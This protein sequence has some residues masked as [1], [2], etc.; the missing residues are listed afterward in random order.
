MPSYSS[1]A[2]PYTPS[3]R[4]ILCHN[5]LAAYRGDAFELGVIAA[6][7]TTQLFFTHVFANLA[8]TLSIPTGN[9]SQ[10]S[11]VEMLSA[12]AFDVVEA[13]RAIAYR[14]TTANLDPIANSP[15]KHFPHSALREFVAQSDATLRHFTLQHGGGDANSPALLP[16]RMFGTLKAY[17]NMR[18]ATAVWYIESFPLTGGETIHFINRESYFETLN[19]TGSDALM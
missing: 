4:Q 14:R 11:L 10:E 19:D 9:L 3:A 8:A 16:D 13:A 18:F 2:V 12:D 15:Y 1:I 7:T 6:E 5:I 17:F